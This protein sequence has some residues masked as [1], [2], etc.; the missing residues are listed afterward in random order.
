MK[1]L[2]L[3]KNLM[4][5]IMFI[6]MDTFLVHIINPTDDV[7]MPSGFSA[8]VYLLEVSNG[9]KLFLEMLT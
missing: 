2:I 9:G 8:T 7:T 6:I 4:L 5:G 3:V 1:T